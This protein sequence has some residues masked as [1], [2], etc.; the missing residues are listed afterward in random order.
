MNGGADSYLSSAKLLFICYLLF[1]GLTLNYGYEKF[2]PIV[3]VA[4][5]IVCCCFF[6][7]TFVR[8]VKETENDK[9]DKGPASGFTGSEEREE[10]F[11]IKRKHAY[12]V[13]GL[14]AYIYKEQNML[15]ADDFEKLTT[16]LKSDYAVLAKE[17]SRRNVRGGLFKNQK[18]PLVSLKIC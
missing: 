11:S 6:L 2:T 4:F 12:R 10:H 17:F 1:V 8:S 18:E 16:M 3:S 14:I 5:I 13:A 7:L 15:T 9:S